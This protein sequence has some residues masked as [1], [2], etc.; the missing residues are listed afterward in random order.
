MLQ[1]SSEGLGRILD[2]VGT[3]S[4]IIGLVQQHHV[5]II[6]PRVEVS[7]AEA[8]ACNAGLSGLTK[9]V[10][11]RVLSSLQ[12]GL[13]AFFAQVASVHHECAVTCS[14]LYLMRTC[15]GFCLSL[16]LSF[17]ASLCP[18]KHS[19]QGDT[20]KQVMLQTNWTFEV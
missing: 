13:T 11:D 14:Q 2:A 9:T 3:V 10:E 20:S 1:A 5:K 12:A 6:Q 17:L 19:V 16:H 15:H 4:V 8:A 18:G 7:G